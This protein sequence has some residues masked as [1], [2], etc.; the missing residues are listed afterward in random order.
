VG[1][2]WGG[3]TAGEEKA[4]GGVTDGGATDWR[5][6]CEEQMQGRAENGECTNLVESYARGPG[7]RC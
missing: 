3:G 4:Q 1:V 7:E 2:E 6:R 5:E